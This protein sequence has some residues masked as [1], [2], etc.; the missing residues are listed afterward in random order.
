MEFERLFTPVRI[1][2]LEIR[3]RIVMLPMTTGYTEKDEEV[4]DRFIN[5]FAER[6]KGGTGL[7]IIPFSPVKAGSPVEPGLY[8][9]RFLPGI[10]RLTGEIH[11]HGA[12]TA[13]QLIISYH[14]VFK[15][16]KPEVVA[17][18][19]VVNQLLRVMPR[20]L[21]EDEITYIVKE[22]GKAA[23]RAREGGF[24]AVE[25]LVGGGYLLNRFLSPIS[26]K[27]NDRY[28]G[29]LENRMRIILEVIDA[30]KKEAGEDFI[31]SC[32]L[33]VEEQMP[34]GH[35]IEDSKIVAKILEEAGIDIINVYTGWHESTVPTVAPSL[36]RG[37]FA[38][39]AAQIKATV[40]VPVIAANRI[41]SPFVAEEI[42]AD[43]K[44][45]LVGMGRALM[46]DPFLPNKAR[47]GRW[48]EIIPC[49]ACSH[50]LTEVMACY[51][52]WGEPATTYCA[53]N[54]EAGREGTDL[55]KVPDVKKKVYVIGG[56]P[57]G[58]EAAII[59]AVRGH[60]VS[61]F[62]EHGRLG[63]RLSLAAIPPYKEEI[64]DLINSFS[65]RLKRAEVD[66]RLN[67][68]VDE[69]L[70]EEEK[71][72]VVIVATGA[73]TTIPEIPGVDLPHV[74]TAEDVL[75]DVRRVR[76]NVIVIGGG[77]VGCETAEHVLLRGE[78]ISSVTILE[79]LDRMADNVSPTYRP[80]FLARLK[81]EGIRM[82]TGVKVVGITKEGVQ[83]EYN[84]KVETVE[85][86][87]VIIAVGFKADQ[88]K[89]RIFLGKTPEVYF[90][91]DC[92]QARMI[93]DA[94]LEG[95]EIGRS[96]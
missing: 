44:A 34:G 33:N 39:L 22:C 62:E 25:I 17:P 15:E 43:G 24:D 31:Y 11:K 92:V 68:R 16:G 19:A 57:A 5:F 91:G 88:E 67:T 1:K 9:D 78:G 70:I 79:M 80:F 65:E 36:P 50:C 30:M 38:H 32:R 86:D 90:V 93:K 61:L 13:A 21:T 23:R 48:K 60:K 71:P 52:K 87:Y 45:D 42:L 14:V 10:R 53:V 75:Q 69:A 7:I 18:S 82:K 12:R 72:D 77:M 94:I 58:M 54:P 55:L 37:A 66:V 59:A 85:G 26:N 6:A 83:V 4:G 95:F 28:G 96:I 81:S 41:N 2:G 20:E 74:V 35:T 51:R 49:L 3:N 84:G 89:T 64:T 8:D 56:G 40:S 73:E 46:A 27:R 76:G 63:G 29:S 47:E